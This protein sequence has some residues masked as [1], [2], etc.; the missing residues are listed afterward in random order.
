MKVKI[1]AVLAAT[2]AL[3]FTTVGSA[4][5]QS[6]GPADQ[7]ESAAPAKVSGVRLQTAM[8]LTSAFGSD[9]SLSEAL[10]SGSKLLSSRA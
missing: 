5:A 8:L 1:A 6:L 2:T 10:N 3:A 7:H 9:F 4:A